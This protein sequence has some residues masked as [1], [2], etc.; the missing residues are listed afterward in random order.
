MLKEFNQVV[1]HAFIADFQLV[2]LIKFRCII[3]GFQAFFTV[4]WVSSIRQEFRQ[5]E[6]PVLFIETNYI[7]N[8]FILVLQVDDH[9]AE[10]RE[11]MQLNFTLL[12]C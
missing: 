12:R 5:A 8:H 6:Q 11:A 10:N 7:N 9:I 2:A 4:V 1:H 3:E